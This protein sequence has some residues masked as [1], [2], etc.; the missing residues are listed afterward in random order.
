MDSYIV[1][2]AGSEDSLHFKVYMEELS[3]GGY[4]KNAAHSRRHYGLF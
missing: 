4:R 1:R 3:S 2:A